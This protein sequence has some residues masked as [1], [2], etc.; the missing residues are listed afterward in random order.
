MLPVAPDEAW[1]VLTDWERQA[2]WMRDADRV[3]VVSS[4]RDGP[5]VMLAVRTRVLNVPIFT[6]RLEVTEWW[7]PERMLMAHRGF[8]RGTGEWQLEPVDGGTRFAWSEDLSL[9]LGPLG[10][11]ALAA[12][13]PVMRLLM[14]A[15]MHDLRRFMIALGPAH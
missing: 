11:L 3:E 14:D 9:P 12:Y 10:R 13:R 15:A 4:H 5:G 6:E 2:D 8:V 1:A 7:P